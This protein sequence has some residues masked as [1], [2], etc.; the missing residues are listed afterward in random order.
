MKHPKISAVIIALNEEENI[1]DAVKSVSWADEVVVVDCGSADR[2]VEIAKAAGAKTYKKK[3]DGYI[4]QKNW[5]NEKAGGEW[6]LSL[7]AD[8]RVTP[9]LKKEIQYLIKTGTDMDGYCIPRR[10]RFL[11]R[12][13]RH[14]HWYPDYQLRL[15]RKNKSAWTGGLVHERVE[16]EGKVGR[17][18]N[19]LIHF[20]Y[21]DIAD[22]TEKLNRYSS[23]WALDAFRD[24]RKTG[25]LN[26]II[27]PAATFMNIYFFR[28]GIL[29]G[30]PGL[31][32]SRSLAYYSFQKK[33]KLY[34]LLREKKKR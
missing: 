25:I 12:Y 26:I 16:V 9:E 20:T 13:I 28:L 33:V 5:A 31:V 22:Q 11:G 34:Q 19:D 2:T 4:A 24:G 18:N 1:L 23:L 15:F 21:K 29:D 10:A 8:E 7:D 17:L 3:W 14:C 30:F 32:I 27:S 6:I